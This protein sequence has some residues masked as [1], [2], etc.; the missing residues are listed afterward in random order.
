MRGS[1]PP[2][3]EKNYEGLGSVVYACIYSGVPLGEPLRLDHFLSKD[4]C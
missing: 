3:P 1:S 4:T 2:R